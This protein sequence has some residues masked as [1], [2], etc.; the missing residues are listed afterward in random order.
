MGSIQRYVPLGDD[1]YFDASDFRTRLALDRRLAVFARA[2][3]VDGRATVRWPCTRRSNAAS[4]PSGT[5][6]SRRCRG[7]PN[8]GESPPSWSGSTTW[9]LISSPSLAENAQADL[10]AVGSCVDGCA[11]RLGV[12]DT[13]LCQGGHAQ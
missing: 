9:P 2:Y 7:L 3:G 5:F 13:G 10:G 11:V 4:R 6:R 12:A 1:V 8:S